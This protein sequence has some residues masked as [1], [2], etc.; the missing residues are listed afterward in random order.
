MEIKERIIVDQIDVR[1]STPANAMTFIDCDF[2]KRL[3]IS[4][5][6]GFK[7]IRFEGCV[8]EAEVFFEYLQTEI[9]FENCRFKEVLTFNG[10]EQDL[11]LA[12]FRF[13][14]KLRIRG[15]YH[16][17]LKLV[18]INNEI[19]Q[20][21]EEMGGLSFHRGTCEKFELKDC[22]LSWIVFEGLWDFKRNVH[23]DNCVA[24]SVIMTNVYIGNWLMVS[25]SEIKKFIINTLTSD[26]RYIE[27]SAS[28]SIQSL[29]IALHEVDRLVIS[30]CLV[31][32]LR[33]WGTNGKTGVLEVKKSTF[34]VLKFDE[35]FNEGRAA[36]RGV[37]CKL[38]GQIA[39]LSSTLGKCNFIDC[40]FS[41][42]TMEFENS[43]VT[44][45]FLS[46]TDFPEFVTSDGIINYTQARMAFGQLHTAFEKQGDT[47]RALEY[48]SREI[49]AHYYSLPFFWN[50]LPPIIHVTKLNLWL[51]KW[52]NNFGRNWMRGVVFSFAIGLACFYGLVISSKEYHIGWGLAINWQL[53]S[54]YFRFMNPLRFFELE[55][56]F[57]QNNGQ[58]YL[59]LT[60]A[61]YVIDFFGRIG[62]A[63]GFYQTIQAFRRFGRK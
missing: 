20:G 51:N 19:P 30:D 2:K 61:S 10:A 60:P 39:I 5:M 21:D 18:G 33:L 63:Y 29:S 37:V 55:A 42:A 38:G 1:S 32:N 46:E 8:F 7:E 54:S 22:R 36:F 48:Q 62:I 50:D 53:V 47:V 41:A 49:E 3:V 34:M 15:P 6:S 16:G 25:R 13:D 43:N 4:Q 57:R 26:H 24:T 23:I 40:D 45:L 14:K 35:V 52:S 9:S 17:C 11:T 31:H 12:A 59:T 28:C 44:E 56:L 27:F 58:S